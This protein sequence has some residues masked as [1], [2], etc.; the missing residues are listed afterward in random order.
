MRRQH[1]NSSKVSDSEMMKFA[2]STSCM[3]LMTA[4]ENDK[5]FLI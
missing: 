3:N 5:R 2:N 1:E 4:Q